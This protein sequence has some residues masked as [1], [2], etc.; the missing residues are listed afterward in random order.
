MDR[1]QQEQAQFTILNMAS[2]L[3]HQLQKLDVEI[4]SL[5]QHERCGEDICV[6]QKLISL[7]SVAT[8]AQTLALELVHRLSLNHQPNTVCPSGCQVYCPWFQVAQ[9][10]DRW[11][12]EPDFDPEAYR[13]ALYDFQ[14]GVSM[15]VNLADFFEL[16]LQQSADDH[17]DTNKMM[18]TA[19]C[20]SSWLRK[21]VQLLNTV[22]AQAGCPVESK[23]R[24][25]I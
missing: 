20:L 6:A 22:G 18:Q 23:D 3:R 1:H 17:G 8:L 5:L 9:R 25:C 21:L 24:Q 19:F 2:D 4:E 12:K 7:I 11:F 10:I 15:A 16:S 14:R 13:L